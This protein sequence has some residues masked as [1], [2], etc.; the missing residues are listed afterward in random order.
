[1]KGLA[2]YGAKC[3]IEIWKQFQIQMEKYDITY[4]EYPHS[5]TERAENFS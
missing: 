5:L 1:M 4:V 2:L 3:T